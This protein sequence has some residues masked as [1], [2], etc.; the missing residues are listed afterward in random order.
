MAPRARA[1]VLGGGWQAVWPRLSS[2]SRHPFL[3]RS[4]ISAP[5]GGGGVAGAF[6]EGGSAGPTRTGRAFESPLSRCGE[7]GGERI[8]LIVYCTYIYT[9]CTPL[10][11][12]AFCPRVR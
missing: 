7:G 4:L 10:N 11:H 3:L 6:L 2:T 1:R 8:A 9:L 12:P 5:I